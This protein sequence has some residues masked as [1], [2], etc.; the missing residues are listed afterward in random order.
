MALADRSF[1]AVEIKANSLLPPERSKTFHGRDV[2][3]PVAAQLACGASPNVFGNPIEQ[4]ETIDFAEKQTPN[5]WQGI[6]L[7]IDRFGNVIT[8]FSVHNH[9]ALHGSP[10]KIQIAG[11]EVERF[12]PTFGAAPP[13]TLFAYF[14]SSGYVEIGMNGASA[15]SVLEIQLG[16]DIF[17]KP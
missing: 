8:N 2:F 3:A 16:S 14:G 6:V 17:L 12:Y 15:A 1:N 4:L 10:S 13:N 5:G 7:S 11:M 9:V